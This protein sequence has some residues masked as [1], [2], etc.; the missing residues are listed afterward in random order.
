M[1]PWA[2]W[3]KYWKVLEQE[4][5]QSW[6]V[7]WKI[8]SK[9]LKTSTGES[10]TLLTIFWCSLICLLLLES[11]QYFKF[12]TL[13]AQIWTFWGN[14]WTWS[15]FQGPTMKTNLQNS[16]L[17]MFTGLLFWIFA[18]FFLIFTF[19]FRWQ[20]LERSFRALALPEK[21]F[22]AIICCS[23][24]TPRG[25][26]IPFRSKPSIGRGCQFLRLRPAKRPLSLWGMCFFVFYTKAQIRTFF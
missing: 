16:K 7:I 21:S 13:S 6:S 3:T 20:E 15:R 12:P 19:F 5:G 24:Q 8:S 9:R 14:F 10:M 1:K 11:A 2:V 22:Q 23:A 25:N 18:I 17:T 4:K 26:S